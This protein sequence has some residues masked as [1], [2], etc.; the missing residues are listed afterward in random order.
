MLVDDQKAF[1][2]FTGDVGVGNLEQRRLLPGKLFLGWRRD[3]ALVGF[4][5]DDLAGL[6]LREQVL[7]FVAFGRPGLVGRYNRARL[8]RTDVHGHGR[9]RE[10]PL[11]VL[12]CGT[13]VDERGV[14]FNFLFEGFPDGMRYHEEH[15]A[16]VGEADFALGRVDVHVEFGIRHIEEQ[17]GDGFALGAVRLVG[18]RNGLG[19]RLTLDG[20]VAHEQVLVVTLPV[21]FGGRGDEP[22]DVDAGFRIVDGEQFFGDTG[23]DGL[24]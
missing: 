14:L 13:Q 5:R 17:H 1:G 21:G 7:D 3:V 4:Q 8:G 16:L 15:E 20:A 12:V 9:G 11:R 19:N 18:L 23:P 2:V 10:L 22:G 24:G 6:G